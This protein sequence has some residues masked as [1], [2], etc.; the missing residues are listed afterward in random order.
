MK[1]Q[2]FYLLLLFL[3]QM[4]VSCSNAGKEN[5]ITTDF[6]QLKAW[7]VSN[8]AF[9]ESAARSGKY[10]IFTGPEREFSLTYETK[11]DALKGKGY[12]KLNAS[13]WFKPNNT[14]K[15]AQ[16][17]AAV[18]SPTGANYVWKSSF[19]SGEGQT[20]EK[21]WK[22]VSVQLDLPANAPDGILKIYAWSPSKEAVVLDDFELIFE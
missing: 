5:V 15:D 2:L 17:V 10:A 9:T 16:W 22:K 18:N 12:S 19:L 14:P 1:N 8:D 4:Q 6:D 7:N 21:G 3:I 13:I 20:D 11:I